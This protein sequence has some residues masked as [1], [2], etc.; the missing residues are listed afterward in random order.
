M[1]SNDL[2]VFFLKYSYVQ[3]HWRPMAFTEVCGS[4]ISSITYRR[5]REGRARKA[6]I[7]AGKIVHRVS[8]EFVAIG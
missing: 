4:G 7:T 8:I 1:E 6:R 5:R 3:Y 2:T